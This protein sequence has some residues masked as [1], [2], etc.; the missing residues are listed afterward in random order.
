MNDVQT[1]KQHA[2]D[3]ILRRLESGG[4][5]PG[6]RLADDAISK[7]L[8]VSRS[9]VREAILQLPGEGLIEQRPRYGAF[10]HVPDREELSELFE[11]RLALESFAA[12][13][14]A[15]RRSN[16]DLKKLLKLTERMS[17]VSKRCS[18]I[19]GPIC[20]AGITEEFLK[21]DYQ[22]HLL[23][24]KMA[25]NRKVF[26][27]I[28]VCRVLSRVFSLAALEHV[29]DVILQSISQHEEFVQ[30]IADKDAQRATEAMAR[31]IEYAGKRMMTAYER[32]DGTARVVSD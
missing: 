6:A 19:S 12:G 9:P 25:G 24:V 22:T 32:V 11:A 1:L 28:R 29:S 14:A 23:V 3:N 4:F 7:E 17:D 20:D 13:W 31:H 10:V 26:Q 15:E 8:G 5:A 18:E 21:V 16:R 27:M 2:Y 30:A